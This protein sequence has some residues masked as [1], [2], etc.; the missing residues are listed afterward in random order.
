[1][2]CL[3]NLKNHLLAYGAAAVAVSLLA[4]AHAQTAAGRA[5]VRDVGGSADYS[6]GGGTWTQ[7]QRGQELRSGAVIRT[8]ADSY[9]DIDLKDNGPG[10][11]LTENTTLGFDKLLVDDTGAERVVETQLDLRAGCV[12]GEVYKSGASSKYEIKTPNAVAGVKGYG[13]YRICA[14]GTV[15]VDQGSAVVVWV[16]A[17]GTPTT[18]VVNANQAFDPTIPGVR[19]PTGP[20][21]TEAKRGRVSLPTEIARFAPNV[22][23][24]VSP[25]S[26]GTGQSAVPTA[27]TGEQPTTRD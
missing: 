8:G 1:M 2:K 7:L 13:T 19:Q 12:A 22:E 25:I 3:G 17:Q 27:A 26:P 14:N 4:S 18:Y 9:V 6:E 24:Y 16:N 21:I 15:V 23:P 20:E 11:H 5:I 10:L